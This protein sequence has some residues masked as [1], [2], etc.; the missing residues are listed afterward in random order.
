M[1]M[2]VTIDDHELERKIAETRVNKG[3]SA[4][5]VHCNISPLAE[6]AVPAPCDFKSD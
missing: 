6:G 4:A 2:A 3:I 1:Y 5:P